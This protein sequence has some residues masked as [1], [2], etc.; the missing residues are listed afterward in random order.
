LKPSREERHGAWGRARREQGARAAPE[1]EQAILREM[2][3]LEEGATVQTLASSKPAMAELGQRGQGRDA[4]R[5]ARQGEG[6][7]S[8]GACQGDPRE[9]D[10]RG[11]QGKKKLRCWRPEA[12]ERLGG[13]SGRSR[14]RGERGE[15]FGWG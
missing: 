10:G 7:G 15:E 9:R 8:R 1:L 13:R 11:M 6:R 3:A 12:A 2:S 4:E 14:G 5:S